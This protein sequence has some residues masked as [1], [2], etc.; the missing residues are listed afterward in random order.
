MQNI[1]AV[2]V[3]DG[4]VGKSCLLISYTTNSFP[5]EYVPTVF[6]NYSANVMVD[7]RPVNLGLWD[8]AGQED[9]D[10]LRPLS[11]PQT[12]VFVLCF[13]VASPTSLENVKSK[14]IAEISHHCPEVPVVLCANKVDLRD[15]DSIISRLRDRGQH[16]ITYD[17]GAAMA[18]QIGAAHYVETS[19]LTQA[20]LK[21]AFDVIMRVAM[22]GERASSYKGKKSKGRGKGGKSAYDAKPA[23]IPPVLPKPTHAP[24]TNIQTSTFADD[25]KGLL[26]SSAEADV[27][28]VVEERAVKAH[29]V[30]LA[31]NSLLF[32][33]I[34]GADGAQSAEA[35]TAAAAATVKAKAKQSQSQSNKAASKSKSSTSAKKKGKGAD[36]KQ[37]QQ[38]KTKKNKKEKKKEEEEEAKV[39]VADTKDEEES[40]EADGGEESEVPE[41]FLCPITQEIM[42]DPV[43]TCDGHTYE[44]T[45]IA[46]WLQTH[47]TAPITGAE[48]EN[49]A[50]IPNHLVRS[51]IKDYL[52]AQK[53]GGSGSKAGATAAKQPKPHSA[54]AVAE[55]QSESESEEEE[56]ETETQHRADADPSVP[57]LHRQINAGQIPG[58][59]SIHRGRTSGGGEEGVAYTIGIS[60]RVSHAVFARVLEF[61]YT[62]I[63]T[64]RDKL[65]GVQDLLAAAELFGLE[66]LATICR[67]VMDDS[68]F[69]NPSI[70]TWLNDEAGAVAKQLFL[71]RPL[72]SDVAFEVEGKRIHAHKAILMGRCKVLAAM[73]SGLFVEDS[74]ETIPIGDTSLESFLAFLE[75][76][77]TDHSPIC[78]SGDSVGILILAN[79]FGLPRLVTLCE[80]YITK[81]VET[82]TSDGIEKAD[83]DVVGLLHLAEQHNADQLVG[84]CRHFIASNYQPM[85]KRPEF[86]TLEGENL[87]YIEAN[88]WPPKSY[89]AE[90]A[91]YEKAIKET[92]KDAKCICM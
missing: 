86:S 63:A 42:K 1:K 6:D 16:P 91:V 39:E 81:E 66:H 12:D 21:N 67:N 14:W 58:F 87:E 82:A 15:D 65:D 85:S 48:L 11:Y 68:E 3:G 5:G 25:F 40:K 76:L 33:R 92:D 61:F 71:N 69:L 32:R 38:K 37:Q 47:S 89:L 46:E 54:P 22:G 23:L 90:L 4:A 77:Y 45:S 55:E 84:F 24:W 83:I 9:Y 88:Q 19:A 34:F 43:L 20:G 30:V 56:E 80:L 28:F 79:R 18:K 7:G 8:T 44:R 35:T 2:V 72:F 64:I 10:R 17:E 78:E 51:Q 50:L 36:D 73:F 60:K 29:R 13:S 26:E 41:H 31:A 59:S 52:D 74:L 53:Q 49:K 57:P 27:K 70:G 62:G 75:F